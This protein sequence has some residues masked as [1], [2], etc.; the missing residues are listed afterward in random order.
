MMRTSQHSRVFN[1]VVLFSLLAVAPSSLW[2]Q[3]MD[4]IACN[5]NPEGTDP[6][7]F[8]ASD[9]D[10][11][12]GMLLGIPFGQSY[13]DTTATC[14]VQPLNDLQVQMEENDAGYLVF[15]IDD[16]V[17]EYFAWAVNSGAASQEE[18]DQFI[19]L[20]TYSTFAFCGNE[21]NAV[22]PGIGV[23]MD[24]YE[25]GYWYLGDMIQYYVSPIANASLGCGDVEA[26]NF[27]ICAIPDDAACTYPPVFCDD[28]LACNFE[29]GSEGT[30]DCVYF[31]TDNFTL[32]ENDFIGL[33]EFEE[34]ESGYA[35]WNDLPVPL[36]QDSTGGPLYYV[37]FPLVEQTLIAG[38]FQ[39][40]VDDLQTLTLSVC[41]DTMNYNSDIAG[42]IDFLWDGTGFLNTFY[43][44]Y[45]APESSFPVACPDPNAC[46]FNACSNPFTTEMCEYVEAGVIVG[47]TL[48][49]NGAT[50][51][52]VYEG[53]QEGSSFVFYSACGVFE[54]DGSNTATL[55]FDF[56][57]DCELC[58]E[59]TTADGCSTIVC[60]TLT[61]SATGVSE[62]ENA[63]W[64]L[65]PNPASN[66]V[67]VNWSG[68]AAAWV[69]YDQQG[70]E[71]RRLTLNTGMT[72]LDVSDLATG[73]YLMGP[74][75][76]T[77]QRLSIVH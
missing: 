47:D 34:C 30:E 51:T 48:V 76:G 50:Y 54:Q 13:L 71:V 61:P 75:N 57:Q 49:S 73:Q 28:P 55:V 5:Y 32:D 33:Y 63:A 31:D 25:N 21:M 22:I 2:S 65:T 19:G 42:D 60:Q 74:V 26:D 53:A 7:N 72:S 3:C 1:T 40:L 16:S 4:E 17:Y 70:R 6:C 59:E 37:L 43:G 77:K 69:I 10:L 45:I 66:Q 18:A 35:G 46:N 9:E 23:V 29:E 20:M 36:T 41:G 8:S 62:V 14:A 27:D 39:V 52:Y 56:P 15:V 64:Q 12:Q 11:S 24:T 58:V 38:G 67:T 68:V 44:G